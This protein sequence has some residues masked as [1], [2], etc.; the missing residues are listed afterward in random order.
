VSIDEVSGGVQASL[1]RVA[2]TRRVRINSVS[3]SIQVSI[4]KDSDVRVESRT[5]SGGIQAFF[6]GN[7]HKGFVGESLDGRLGN[8]SAAMSLAAVSG[9]ITISP[10]Q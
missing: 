9:G 2:D 6:S 8:G 5:V 1:G 7:V 3:G 4:A 10:Q